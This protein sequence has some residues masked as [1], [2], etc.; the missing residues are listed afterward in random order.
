M[1]R[2]QEAAQLAM[3]KPAASV[4]ARA[5][6]IH[7]S[8]A[9]RDLDRTIAFYREVFGYRVLLHADDL[10]DE[11][12]RLTDRR[13]LTV[14]L[15]QLGRGD[16]STVIE[17]IEFHDGPH[18]PESGGGPVP[19]GHIAFAVDDLDA[20]L[21]TV[22]GKGAALLGEIVKFPEGRCCYCREPGGSVF[23]FEETA[24]AA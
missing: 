9:V 10:T 1:T 23:E 12:A 17:F 16:D 8:L 7:V 14:R 3:A 2:R 11:V 6:A 22:R 20:A 13:G 4:T 19:V 15:A 5:R 18:I 24:G 21:A